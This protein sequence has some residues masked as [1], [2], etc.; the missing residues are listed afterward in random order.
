MSENF[1]NPFPKGTRVYDLRHGW[2]SVTNVSEKDK[3]PVKVTFDNWLQE[4]YHLDGRAWH[5]DAKPMLYKHN[6]RIVEI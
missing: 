4:S 1:Y 2:G 3:R 6:V 5:E